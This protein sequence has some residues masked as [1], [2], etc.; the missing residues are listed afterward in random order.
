MKLSVIVTSYNRWPLLKNAVD[1]VIRQELHSYDKGEMEI[2]VVDDC[3]VQKGV[4]EYLERM[5][6]E[7]LIRYISSGPYSE[8]FRKTHK[9]VSVSINLALNVAK[10]DY[11]TYLCDD[12]L[13]VPGRCRKMMDIIDQAVCEMVVG[14]VNWVTWDGRKFPQEKIGFYNYKK[15]FE[16]GH[17][18]LVEALKKSGSNFI[19]HD[20]I[21]HCKTSRRWPTNNIHT[22][23]DWRFWCKL[24][25]DGF[26]VKTIDDVVAEAIL[27]ETWR[28]GITM[29][30]VLANRSLGGSIMGEV[31]QAKNVSNKVQV[32]KDDKGTVEPGGRVDASEVTLANGRL[33]PGFAWDDSVTVHD[34]NVPLKK[35]GK[36]K[37]QKKPTEV[38][39]KKPEFVEDKNPEPK[40]EP[41]KNIVLPKE[42]AKE[43]AVR[44]KIADSKKPTPKPISK[45]TPVPEVKP[46]KKTILRKKTTKRKPA[47]R[48][49]ATKKKT[50]KRKT[51]KKKAAKKKTAKRKT[52]KKR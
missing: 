8:E 3:S 49:S 32:L 51:V 4:R 38:A 18:E 19:C 35:K 23:V 50:A 48:K 30:Q 42:T 6:K 28:N 43:K 15:P 40:P 47:K 36:P 1:S 39:E 37:K 29:E 31:K 22:P 13:F 2:I 11:I 9:M 17:E 41:E 52:A 12:D 10:G 45:P 44:A 5:H 24:S 34:K 20:T 25:S 26:R 7:G 46:K 14:R 33:W 16:E 27:P 21:M